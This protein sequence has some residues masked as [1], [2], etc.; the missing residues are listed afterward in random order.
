MNQSRVAVATVTVNP[1]IDQT[2]AIANFST[3]DVN[4]VESERCD[5]GG[6]GVNV[7]AFLADLGFPTAVTG[8]LGRENASYFEQLFAHKGIVDRFVRVPGRTRVNV[9]ITDRVRRRVTEINFPGLHAATADVAA[10]EREV[11][12]LMP[13][14]PWFVVSGSLPA[15]VDPSFYGKLVAT[16]KAAG[17][18]VVLD[19]SGEALRAGLPASPFAI[20]PNIAELQELLGTALNG[21][22]EIA[23][24]ARQLIDG[25]IHCVVVSMGR[26]G[27]LFVD[28]GECLLAE[29]PEIVAESTVGAGDAMVAGLVAAKIHGDSLADCARYATA[30]AVSAL[31]QLGPRLS[32]PRTIDA[33]RQQ[34]VV[35]SL[36]D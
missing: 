7:A 13:D 30:T 25:G 28:A 33:L 29:P 23:R 4:R 17:R 2:V 18:R 20:K 27:A 34:I 11:V 9:K 22:V 36:H 26:A 10:L 35:R 12:A 3:G 6:K 8:L 14:Y 15:G 19:S 1:A 5:P 16:L 24:A 32:S 31:G 21:E